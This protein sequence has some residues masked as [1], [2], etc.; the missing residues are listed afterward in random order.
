LV[1]LF[2]LHPLGQISAKNYSL[3]TQREHDEI[4]KNIWMNFPADD[5]LVFVKNFSSEHMQG[6]YVFDM[7]NNDRLFSREI[8]IKKSAWNLRNV[9]IIND[10]KMENVPELLI[11]FA[12]EPA[13]ERSSPHRRNISD[14]IHLLSR[15]ISANLIELLSKPPKKHSIYQLYKLYGIQ[16]YSRIELRLYEMELQRLLAN[17][18][19]FILFALIAAI[20]CFPINRYNTKTGVSIK[21]IIISITMR[22]LNNILESLAYGGVVPI[23]LA[24]WAVVLMAI[25][26]SIAALIWKEA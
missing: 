16:K 8:Y 3:C 7:K 9:N 12:N 15:N 1:W 14:C 25:C 11:N 20:I 18:M 24:S 21:I 6:L 13:H 19:H 10:G 23:Y 22:F 5:M 4:N 2:G 17:C 26:I